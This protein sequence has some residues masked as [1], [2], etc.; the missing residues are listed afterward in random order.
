RNV[1]KGATK[2]R[3]LVRFSGRGS[4]TVSAKRT[5]LPGA[6]TLSSRAN[7]C[8][9]NFTTRY[10]A[11]QKGFVRSTKFSTSLPMAMSTCQVANCGTMTRPYQEHIGAYFIAMGIDETGTRA[12]LRGRVSA[13]LSA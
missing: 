4:R 10:H 12:S 6:E 2:R 1:L 9:N 11:P 5:S 13:E 3:S 7:V 8:E